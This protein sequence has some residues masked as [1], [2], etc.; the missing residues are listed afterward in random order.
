VKKILVVSDLHVGSTS[1]I[2]PPV[3]ELG[4]TATRDARTVH[5]SPTQLEFYN[6]W[7]DVVKTAGKIDACFVLGDC[8]DGVDRKS[9]GFS[10]W[11]TDR[12]AQITTAADL[13]SMVEFTPPPKGKRK[14]K[15]EARPFIGVEGSRYHVDSNTSA[16]LAVMDAIGGAFGTDFAVMVEGT[17]IH[18]CH[19]IGHTTSPVSKATAPAKE[20]AHAELSRPTYGKFDLLL[21]GHRHDYYE[22][23]N[24]ETHI[25]GCP[26]WKSRDHFAATHGLGM[27]AKHIGALLLTVDKDEHWIRPLLTRLTPAHQFQEVEI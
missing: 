16:D 20:A 7:C 3:V 19:A 25:A 23:T 21:R 11:T 27:A 15:G 9:D 4:P 18:L 10:A 22:W 12:R 13:L 26:S 1:A 24:G 6:A 8:V 2:M 14:D 17:R 5:A